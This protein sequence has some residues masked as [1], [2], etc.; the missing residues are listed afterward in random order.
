MEINLNKIKSI[1]PKRAEV[2][3][4]KYR[5]KS[6]AIEIK[7]PYPSLS[8]KEHGEVVDRHR[9]M[10]GAENIWEFYTEE[11]GRHWYIFL[12]GTKMIEVEV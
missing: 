9:E 7:I 1:L 12:N 6:P 3:F 11:I 4:I 8:E 5:G 2:N 10:I